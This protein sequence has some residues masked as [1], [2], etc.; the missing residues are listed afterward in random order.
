MED[1]GG[2]RGTSRFKGRTI[3][4]PHNAVWGHISHASF[5]KKNPDFILRSK[6]NV[7]VLT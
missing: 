2:E 6:G 5:L 3:A 4:L 1:K 7:F